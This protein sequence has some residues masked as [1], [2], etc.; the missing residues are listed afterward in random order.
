[1]IR[2]IVPVLLITLVFAFLIGNFYV[3]SENGVNKFAMTREKIAASALG[4]EG[5]QGSEPMTL[6]AEENYGEVIY[7]SGID[8]IDSL[9]WVLIGAWFSLLVFILWNWRKN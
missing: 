8:S 2:G 6:N 5:T 9:A 1:M 4:F 3:M 7:N